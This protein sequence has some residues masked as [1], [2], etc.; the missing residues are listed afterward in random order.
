MMHHFYETRPRG[1]LMGEQEGSIIALLQL[2]P[3]V[4]D[5]AGNAQRLERFIQT[6]ASSG[7]V[8]SV[9][10]E[11][12]I[13]GYPPRDLL[14]QPNF[15]EIAQQAVWELDVE[16]PSLIG[17]PTTPDHD[18]GKPGNGVA[19]LGNKAP[20]K[21]VARK[22]LLPTYDVFDEARYFD[23][24]DRP[25]IARTLSGPLE[26]GVT[27]CEDAW[28]I[29]GETPSEYDADPIEQLAEWGRQGVK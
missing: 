5:I 18:R 2:N 15:V 11:L 6:A 16:I 23:S 21:I 26:L 28:Q 4:G 9:S 7:A 17:T 12:A 22:Q 1:M 3:T 24:D 14:M 27:V 10:T 25:G 13:C 29:A 19:L 8:A 20:V